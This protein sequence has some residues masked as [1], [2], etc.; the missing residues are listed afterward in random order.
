MTRTLPLQ[1]LGLYAKAVQGGTEVTLEG[2]SRAL[3]LEDTLPILD[4]LQ[5]V[6]T[7]IGQC[8]LQLMP[9]F[10]AGALDTIRLLRPINRPT[11]DEAMVRTAICKG[12]TATQEFKSSLLYDHKR[13][14]AAPNTPLQE[15][16]A[17]SVLYSCL[18][19]VAAFLTCGGGGIYVGIGDDE[20]VIGIQFDF[21]LLKGGNGDPDAWELELRNHIEGRFK[22]G[23]LA[24][25]YVVVDFVP[26]DN[27]TIAH[28]VVQGRCQ[29]SFLK[30][31]ASWALYRRQGNRSVEVT[32]DEV[33]EFLSF[34]KAQAW[35]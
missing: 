28:V 22:D 3:E 27:V 4:Q 2:L 25:D 15:L 26:I 5:I 24:N 13:A 23:N 7:T 35:F 14:E 8:G 1:F 20:Q 29:L 17:Q 34:R 10:A 18:K 19:T 31:D 21:R 33:E 32:I 6:K 11:I 9:D 12:E 16:K 30:K